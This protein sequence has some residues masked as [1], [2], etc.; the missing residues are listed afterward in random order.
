M[1][2]TLKNWLQIQKIKRETMKIA[3]EVYGPGESCKKQRARYVR[4]QV[5]LWKEAQN[6]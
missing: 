3:C 5:A 6:V 1:F 4:G 2:K